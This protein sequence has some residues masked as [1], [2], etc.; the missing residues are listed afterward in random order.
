MW[1]ES[2]PLLVVSVS[3]RALAQAARRA[4]LRV[5]VLDLFN[6]LDT[7]ACAEASE[8]VP[9]RGAGLDPDA[10]IAAAERHAPA[11]EGYGVVYGSGFEHCPEVLERLAE[12]RELLGAAPE[13]VRLLKDPRSFFGLLEHLGLPCPETRTTRP[14]TAD[15]WLVKRI[16]GAGGGHV[17]SLGQATPVAPNV[18][19]QRRVDGRPCSVLLLADGRSARVVGWSEQWP[20][21]GSASRPYLYGGAVALGQP[22]PGVA[23]PLCEAAPGLVEASGLRGLFSIDF[24][25]AAGGFQ[26]LEVNPRPSATFELHEGAESLLRAHIR[27]CRGELPNGPLQRPGRARAHA[28][29]YADYGLRIAAAVRWPD[30]TADRPLPGTLVDTGQPVCTIRA[31]GPDSASARRLVQVRR[32]WLRSG[33]ARWGEAA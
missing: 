9:M 32:Q 24:M 19:Y 1:P 29:L 18:Y 23:E 6:D 7:A 27:A 4:G 28:L 25:Y 8:A 22:P 16:G 33:M 11:G 26:V 10:L 5:R 3:G 13:S 12:G 20:A 2:R 31:E 14:A 15:G 21:G 30:W 17:Q